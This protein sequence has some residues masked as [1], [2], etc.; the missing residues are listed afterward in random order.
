LL[1]LVAVLLMPVLM[2]QTPGLAGCIQRPYVP[3]E[4]AGLLGKHGDCQLM[5]LAKAFGFR[6]CM[7]NPH[8]FSCLMLHSNSDKICCASIH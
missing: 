4:N 5:L 8:A 3:V 7:L 6:H 2:A 1:L